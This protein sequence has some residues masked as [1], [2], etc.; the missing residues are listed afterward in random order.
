MTGLWTHTFTP[1][2]INEA[3]INAAGWRWNELAD[4]PQSPLGLPNPAYI[5]D[6]NNGNN[7]GTINAQGNTLGGAAGS[8]FDQWTYGAKDVV[9]KVQGSHT[10]KFGGE[11]TK[12]AL[13][14]GSSLVRSPQL[15]VPELL[16][17]P[18]RRAHIPKPVYSIPPLAFQ[19]TSAKT[20]ARPS[21]ASSFRT[22]S[23]L[24]RI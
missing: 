16:G 22:A 23:R 18:Q 5:G 17:F 21:M 19:R 24:S 7:I 10:L 8:V 15:G 14:P 6:P 1:T 3:R 9:T 12:L 4:N 11:L 2:L 13:R 20:H